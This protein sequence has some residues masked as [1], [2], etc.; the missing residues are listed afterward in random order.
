[1]E[2]LPVL[3]GLVQSGI[4]E[5]TGLLAPHLE[6]GGW[7]GV[8]MDFCKLVGLQGDF[9]LNHWQFVKVELDI[10][11]LLWDCQVDIGSL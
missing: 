7:E 10:L 11:G 6:V 1:M 8:I 4:H 2:L 5:V 9:S 3:A